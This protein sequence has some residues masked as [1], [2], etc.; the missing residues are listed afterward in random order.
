MTWLSGGVLFAVGAI[1]WVAYLLPSMLRRRHAQAAELHAAELEQALHTLAETGELP[2]ESL[3]PRDQIRERKRL[4]KQE[5]AIEREN[6]K[7]L[8][9]AEL[10]R[11]AEAKLARSDARHSAAARRASLIRLRMAAS[12]VLL[13]SLVTVLAGS[14]AM[15]FG[16]TWMIAGA[17]VMGAVAAVVT[18]RRVVSG[19]RSITESTPQVSARV[20][21][22]AA[23]SADVPVAAVSR[24]WTPQH[25]PSP[26]HLAEGSAAAAT[27]ASNDAVEALRRRA[28]EVAAESAQPV[29]PSVAAAR[30]RAAA[31][32]AHPATYGKQLRAGAPTAKPAARAAGQAATAAERVAARYASLDTL[33]AVTETAFD[34][35]EVLQRRRAV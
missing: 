14:V 34:V 21:G 6:L 16:V 8:H 35:S 1:L 33:D 20:S 31:M 27:I 3:S 32:A 19:L 4:D 12:W 13:L 18:L 22:F 17:G 9:E 28:R 5:R 23:H 10:R 25:L 11:K 15:F 30:A 2:M 24:G 29:L 26:L 7:T